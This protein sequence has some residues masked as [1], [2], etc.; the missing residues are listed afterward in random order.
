LPAVQ[1][2]RLTG[3]WWMLPHAT[4]QSIANVD[5]GYARA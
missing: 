3:L 1:Y 4:G 2:P 5:A